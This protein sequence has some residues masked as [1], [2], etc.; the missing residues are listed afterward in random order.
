MA[1]AAHFVWDSHWNNAWAHEQ[2][3]GDVLAF[4]MLAFGA[5]YGLSI[6]KDQ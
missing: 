2:V 6:W 1:F 4:L 5:L 3:L